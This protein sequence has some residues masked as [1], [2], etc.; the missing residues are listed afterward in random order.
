MKV[1]ETLWNNTWIAIATLALLAGCSSSS[2]QISNATGTYTIDVAKALESPAE[3]KLS[4]LGNHVC[5]VPLETTDK[6]LVGD[7]PDIHI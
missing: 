2:T 1:K 3:L 7:N 4:Q 6:S 5:Y